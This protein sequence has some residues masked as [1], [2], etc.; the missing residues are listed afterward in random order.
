[1]LAFNSDTPNGIVE[2]FYVNGRV[3]A[4]VGVRDPNEGMNIHLRD[5]LYHMVQSYAEAGYATKNIVFS[6]MGWHKEDRGTAEYLLQV[7]GLDARFVP[8]GDVRL[9]QHRLCAQVEGK[10]LPIDVWYRLHPLEILA[11]DRDEEGFPTGAHVL[12]V[13]AR[14]QLAII[15]PPVALIAQTKALQALIWN[16]HEQGLFF[17]EEE[18]RIIDTY[19][20]P[21]YME[22]QFLGATSY[23][24]KPILGQAGGAVTLFNRQGIPVER[25]SDTLYWDQPMVYQKR[26]EMGMVQAE[27]AQGIYRGH[28]LWSS[29]FINGRSSAIMARIDGRMT[30]NRSYFLPVGLKD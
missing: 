20:L 15:N 22:N 28:L 2:S 21:T 30:G 29:F 16:L 1:M 24:T 10:L 6:A 3:C 23:V 18:H 12:E 13:I 19:M 4:H 5:A 17:T 7:S 14:R 25:H 8:L 9:F 26:V 27:T 11:E